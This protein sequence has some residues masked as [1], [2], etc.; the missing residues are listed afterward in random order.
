MT[1]V[2]ACI[3]GKQKA[4]E[5]RLDHCEQPQKKSSH[6]MTATIPSDFTSLLSKGKE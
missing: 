5:E 4:A 3:L 2:W 6:F 1:N